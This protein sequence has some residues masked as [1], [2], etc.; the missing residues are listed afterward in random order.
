M[1]R[2]SGHVCRMAGTGSS[3]AHRF[4]NRVSRSLILMTRGAML[5]FHT[6]MRSSGG[7]LENS[8]KVLSCG[9]T[10]VD[11]DGKVP[12]LEEGGIRDLGL[13]VVEDI[14]GRLD[15]KKLGALDLEGIIVRLMFPVIYVSEY[16]LGLYGSKNT[17][18]HASQLGSHG[19]FH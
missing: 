3:D 18:H 7:R 4:P 9:S 5:S 6:A 12:F 2:D 10:R 19:R 16:A 13:A 1:A 11:A 14:I 8:S 17:M 15:Q